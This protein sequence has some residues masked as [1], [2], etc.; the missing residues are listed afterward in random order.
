MD[1]YRFSV[2]SEGDTSF[3][4]TLT[5]ALELSGYSKASHYAITDKG[6][7]FFW[8]DPKDGCKGAQSLPYPMSIPAIVDF[9]FNWLEVADYGERPDIDGDSGKGWTIYH[10]SWGHVWGSWAGLIAIAPAWAL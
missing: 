6:L 3:R 5:L 7:A 1:N 2:T 8:T 10:E 9:A 4:E